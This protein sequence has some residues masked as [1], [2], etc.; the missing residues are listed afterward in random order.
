MTELIIAFL[1][2]CVWDPN[3]HALNFLEHT[4]V[5]ATFEI[6]LESVGMC[7]KSSN[8]EFPPDPRSQ[9]DD[10]IVQPAI[11]VWVVLSVPSGVAYQGV[12]VCSASRQR[13]LAEQ[14]RFTCK[15]GRLGISSCVSGLVFMLQH[16]IGR[17]AVWRSDCLPETGERVH[18]FTVWSGDL[19]STYP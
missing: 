16:R 5:D 14:W 13:P 2:L 11:G 10:S 1:K 8:P 4:L 12:A 18:L 15:P 19:W 17:K 6:I 3:R 7:A 9:A